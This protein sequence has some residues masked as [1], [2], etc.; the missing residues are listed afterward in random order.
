MEKKLLHHFNFDIILCVQAV[1]CMWL[2][3]Q[4]TPLFLH[5]LNTCRTIPPYQNTITAKAHSHEHEITN[6]TSNDNRWRD[7][8]THRCSKCQSFDVSSG[9]NTA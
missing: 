5:T 7:V 9:S 8:G 2:I 1:N 4:Q 6:E 3:N